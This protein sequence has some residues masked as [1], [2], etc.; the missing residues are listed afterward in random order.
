M[1]DGGRGREDVGYDERERALGVGAGTTVEGVIE[2]EDEVSFE[3]LSN[4]CIYLLLPFLPTCLLSVYSR[5]EGSLPL[6]SRFLRSGDF[7][8]GGAVSERERVRVRVRVRNFRP[9]NFLS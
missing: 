8:G 5:E 9:S 6:F 4:P 7:V 1:R 3:F 2:E